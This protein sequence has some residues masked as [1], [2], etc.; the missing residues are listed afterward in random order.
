MKKLGYPI[1]NEIGQTDDNCNTKVI[2][3][4]I[5]S[6]TRRTKY[7]VSAIEQLENYKMFMVNYVEHNASITVTV[8]ENEWEEV[9]QWIWDNWDCFVGISFLNLDNNVYPLAPFEAISEDE[10][11]LRA[12]LVKAFDPELIKEFETKEV[13]LDIGNES[14]DS[15]VCPIR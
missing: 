3:F 14:C 13:D 4:P 2:E 15:G 12:G 6:S 5:K 8:R 7:D 11:S 1:L 9:E 10:Y